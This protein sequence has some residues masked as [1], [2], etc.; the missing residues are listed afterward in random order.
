MYSRAYDVNF[1]MIFG[2]IVIKLIPLPLRRGPT[3]SLLLEP[4]K[5][6]RGFLMKKLGFRATPFYLYFQPRAKNTSILRIGVE[7]KSRALK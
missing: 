1:M 3:G 2:I 4:P 6:G 5:N 7:I